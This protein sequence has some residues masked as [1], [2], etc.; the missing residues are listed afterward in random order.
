MDGQQPKKRVLFLSKHNS[1]RSQM[2]EALLLD[3]SEGKVD[4]FSAG[5]QPTTINDYA[6]ASMQELGIDI[7]HKHPKPLEFFAGQQFDVVVSLCA[8]STEQCPT[9]PGAQKSLVWNVANPDESG[10]SDEEKLRSF[11]DLRDTLTQKIQ[12]ELLALV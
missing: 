9:F 4:A 1:A 10:G 7:S 6:V 3:F 12:Q 11:R 2:A 5:P 8:Q